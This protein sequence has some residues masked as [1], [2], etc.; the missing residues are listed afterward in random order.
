MELLATRA[1]KQEP[2]GGP[3]LILS[4]FSWLRFA[5]RTSCFN[6]PNFKACGVVFYNNFVTV[7]DDAKGC[8]FKG[9]GR[10]DDPQ[11]WTNSGTGYQG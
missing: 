8:P 4:I 1:G 10:M 2:G 7:G 11:A 9:C 5:C 3:E 6:S